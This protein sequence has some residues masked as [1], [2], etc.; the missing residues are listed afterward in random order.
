M[1]NEEAQKIP[2]V[3]NTIKTIE[4]QQEDQPPNFNSE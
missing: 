3:E 1:E 4:I 2:S